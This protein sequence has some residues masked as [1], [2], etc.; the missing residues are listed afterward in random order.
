MIAITENPGS[1]QQSQ[2]IDLKWHI[3]KQIISLKM[4][5]TIA[6]YNADQ[7]ADILTKVLP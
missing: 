2:H 3:I 6:C 4:I 1:T 5:S 7:I